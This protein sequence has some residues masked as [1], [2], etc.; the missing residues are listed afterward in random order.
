M[1]MFNI[2]DKVEKC[3]GDYHLAGVVVAAFTTVAGKER[4][5]VD[6]T[7]VAPGMLHI[8]SSQNLRRIG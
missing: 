5:V 2:G 4:Y 6:H 8:Y 7:P 1:S 3:T